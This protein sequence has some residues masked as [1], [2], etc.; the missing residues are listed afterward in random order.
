MTHPHERL[1]V[2]R[3]ADL[4]PDQH[5]LYEALVGG[6]R[7]QGP[8]LFPLV[9]GEGGLVGPFNAFLLQPAVGSPLQGLGAALRYGTSLTDRAREI[10]ILLVAAHWESTFE[11]HAHEAVGRHVGLTDD[12]LD[13]LLAGVV[14]ALTDGHE[15]AVADVVRALLDTG[16]LD[17]AA[18]LAA[19]RRLGRAVLFELTTLVGY[20]ATLALQLR[21]FR[22]GVP[23]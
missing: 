4:D 19:E 21:V 9:D 10:A 16:D 23:R 22:V 8:Q 7:A 5:D 17:D 20:Y 2:L 18:F 1:P 14:G 11:L 6:P 13:D 12:E 3:P 15:R